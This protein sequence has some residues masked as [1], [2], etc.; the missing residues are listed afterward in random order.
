MRSDRRREIEKQLAEEKSS[1][2]QK[3][4]GLK[5]GII[6]FVIVLLAAGLAVGGWY[7][8]E[9]KD[10]LNDI[11]GEDEKTDEEKAEEAA[12]KMK[13]VNESFNVYISGT[14]Q[15]GTRSDVNMIMT[16][17]PVTNKILLTSIPRDYYVMLPSK[18]AMD[19][20]TH[21][22]IYGMEET[23]GA[24]EKTFGIDIDYYLRVNYDC[25]TGIVDAIGG[26]DV[27]SEH[28][29]TTSGMGKLNGHHFVK[30]TNHLDGKAALAFSRERHSFSD[31]DMQRNKNQ[32]I[33]LKAI[34]EKAVSDKA[35]LTS[36]LKILNAL[37]GNMK[38]SIS[39]D[40]INA[41]VIMQ[42]KTMPDWDIE[43][44]SVKGTNGM[45]SCYALGGAKA[46]IV[47]GIAEEETKAIEVIKAAMSTGPEVADDGETDDGETAGS[48]ASE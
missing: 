1:K 17:N 48:E 25:L 2:R 46:A 33:V 18:N 6:T 41:L 15:D 11:T 21:S 44:Q 47:R 22:S 31:G 23:V 34:I 28:E 3:K 9:T 43:R 38:T 37:S 8:K 7:L 13:V 14:D 27:V 30:G 29:F 39:A 4:K 32:E 45:G 24:A 26:V 19:K 10:F 16:V 36:Y 5:A 40:E 20:L 12:M 42:L 35:I